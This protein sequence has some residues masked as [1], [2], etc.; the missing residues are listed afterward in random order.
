MNNK[1][2]AYLSTGEILECSVF[3]TIFMSARFRV[4]IDDKPTAA[5][6]CNNETK[7]PIAIICHMFNKT[8]IW[9]ADQFHQNIIKMVYE[10]YMMDEYGRY[11]WDMMGLE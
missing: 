5:F 11:C 6:I 2:I 1:Y 8:F 9:R 3:K 4:R 7:K 10:L